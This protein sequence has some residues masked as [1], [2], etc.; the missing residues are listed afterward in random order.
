MAY[1]SYDKLWRG[2]FCSNDSAKVKTQVRDLNQLKLK[3]NDFHR[4]NEN[5]ATNFDPSDN[6]NLISKAQLNTKLTHI[7]GRLSI[8]EKT[9][10][11]FKFHY[12]KQSVEKTLIEKAVKTT[13]QIFCDNGLFDNFII[14]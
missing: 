8:N 6:S 13:I 2:E 7:E 14:W 1:A 3:L 12:N 10:N 9:C 4:K 11:E 5:V